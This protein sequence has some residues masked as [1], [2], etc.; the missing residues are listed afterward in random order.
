MLFLL[1][2]FLGGRYASLL[3]AALGAAFIAWGLA[4]SSKVLILVGAAFIVW[5]LVT[6]VGALRARGHSSP[7]AAA[8]EHTRFE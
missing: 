2:R 1:N 5:G 4:A 3:R 8:G 6:G 7:N